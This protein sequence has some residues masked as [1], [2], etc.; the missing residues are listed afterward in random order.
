[1]AAFIQFV[2]E[3]NA[4]KILV[5]FPYSQPLWEV[6]VLFKQLWGE[7]PG[8]VTGEAEVYFG[9]RRRPRSA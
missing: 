3:R 9:K 5:L 2:L 6:C 7:S 8:R 4:P 1:V